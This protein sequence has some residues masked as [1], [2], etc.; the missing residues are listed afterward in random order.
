[1]SVGAVQGATAEAA[2]STRKSGGRKKK[3]AR[4]I[5]RILREELPQAF[6][7][8][9]DLEAVSE[10]YGVAKIEVLAEAVLALLRR[11]MGTSPTPMRAALRRVA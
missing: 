6:A 9:G 4:E 2:D 5:A 3:R 1:M 8:R 10:D 7:R 11:P